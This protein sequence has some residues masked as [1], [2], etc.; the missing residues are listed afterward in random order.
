MILQH[1]SCKI[2]QEHDGKILQEKVPN[3]CLILHGTSCMIWQDT[4]VRSYKTNH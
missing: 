4:I 3:A 1:L 2:I